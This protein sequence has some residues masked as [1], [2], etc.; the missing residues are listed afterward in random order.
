LVIPNQ[1][2]LKNKEKIAKISQ[3]L[4]VGAFKA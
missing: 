3:M 2:T 1:A 4:G